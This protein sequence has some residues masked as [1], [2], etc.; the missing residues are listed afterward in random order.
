MTSNYNEAVVEWSIASQSDNDFEA[1]V[2]RYH[3][4][5]PS[6]F[7]NISLPFT[8][9]DYGCTDGG[10]SVPPLRVIIA[11]VRE[12][13]PDMPIQVYLNDLPECRFDKTIDTVTKGLKLETE[14][15]NVFLMASG[16]DFT[17]QVFPRKSI[18]I[19][20]STLTCMI[21]SHPPAPLIDNIFFVVTKDSEHTDNSK[22]WIDSLKKH[23]GLFLD[24]RSKELRP[25][26]QLFVSV[27]IMNEEHDL[28]E[29]QKKEL[30]FYGK[31]AKKILPECLL[32]HGIKATEETL[33]ACM[34]TTAFAF[35]SHYHQACEA[36]QDKIELLESSVEEVPDIFHRIYQSQKGQEGALQSFG[37]N[38]AKYIKG[39]WCDIL[40]E[41]LERR[42]SGEAHASEKIKKISADLFEEMIPRY[43]QDNVDIYPEFYQIF[44]MQFQKKD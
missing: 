43:V 23:F 12:I 38:V 5:D 16:K 27:M 7:T 15:K 32:K 6:R 20:F 25:H 31:I 9:C 4:A 14:V 22:L 8:I 33:A 36:V 28:K 29:Y 42:L 41:G 35:P 34:K 44:K 40:E 13:N 3:E 37:D 30:E 39:F 26:G 21:I 2:K 10:A 24:M 19:G 11:A 18:D 1:C 17:S